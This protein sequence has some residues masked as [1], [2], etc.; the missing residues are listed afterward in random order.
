VLLFL[1]EVTQLYGVPAAFVEGD[2]LY[3]YYKFIIQGK[4]NIFVAFISTVSQ[5]DAILE[6]RVFVV[7]TRTPEAFELYLLPRNGVPVF[8]FS[9]YSKST[10]CVCRGCW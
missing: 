2:V 5:S 6:T 9:V 1:C 4:Q 8:F 3:E 10:P 7:V